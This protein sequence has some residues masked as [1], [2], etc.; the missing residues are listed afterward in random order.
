MKRQAAEPWATDAYGREGPLT[1]WIDA[2]G[3][4]TS[5]EKSVAALP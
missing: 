3:A 5:S 4:A 2:T 1:Q